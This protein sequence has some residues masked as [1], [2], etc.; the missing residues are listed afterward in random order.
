MNIELRSFD[1][2]DYEELSAL[3]RRV[4]DHKAKTMDDDYVPFTPA[5]VKYSVEVTFAKQELLFGIYSGKKLIGT[6]GGSYIPIQF[7]GLRLI[8]SAVTFYAI[9]PEILPLDPDIRKSIFELLIA[10][11]KESDIDLVWAII[12]KS[13]NKEELK[14]LK[15]WL[16]FTTLNKNVE[17]LVKLLGSE[18]VD[19]LREKKEM[20]IV[21]A[22]MAKL[23]AGM[24][25]M[26]LPMGEIRNATP[27]DYPKIIELLNG[28]SKTLPLTQIW[29]QETFQNYVAVSSQLDS[30]IDYSSLKE[31][32]P[33]TEFGFHMKVWER[34]Q[35]IIAA[36]LYRIVF[37]HF[38]NGD[39][40]F[41]FWDYLAFAQDLEFSDKK[42]FLVN[43]FNQLHRKAII[44]TL[45]LPYYDFK[46]FDKA[47]LMAER[48]KTP[49]IV[50]PLTEKAQTILDLEK[51]KEF[52]LPFPD[53]AI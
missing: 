2:I 38:K 5:Y 48:R 12:I 53:F 3:M 47:G 31:E 22:K 44:I 26:D 13:N 30:T 32:F 36:I 16:N 50:R 21:L 39:A 20:N 34:E 28:Y 51:L 18:G 15:E 46:T 7:R 19:V 11:L 52:Y 42:A 1:K 24:E 43:M 25:H 6:I 33:D 9:D 8:G 35:Q 23:M 17:S 45:F 41:A 37:V 14:I 29:T 10:K 40:P 4:Q 49:L 27:E